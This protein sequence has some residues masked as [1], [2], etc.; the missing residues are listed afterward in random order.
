MKEIRKDVPGTIEV[1]HKRS[2]LFFNLL[3]VPLDAFALLASF[4]AAYFIRVEYSFKP[5]VY[6]V[7]GQEYL[8]A[9][10]VLAPVSILLFAL[11]GLYNF[12]SVR[13]RWREYTRVLIATSGST[14][15]LIIVDFFSTKPIFPS[16]A[17]V[18]YGYA[19]SSLSI[20][21]LRFLL[22]SFQRTLF[23]FGIGRRQVVVVGAG[24]AADEITYS[25]QRS[26]GYQLVGVIP[27][28][29]GSIASLQR[30]LSRRVIDE[31]FLADT[32]VSDAE[33]IKMIQFAHQKQIIFKY[34]PGLASLYQTRSHSAL[35]ADLPVIEVIRTPL[36]GWWR[37][38]KTVFDWLG[39]LLGVILLSPFFI[40][41]AV[42]IKVTEGGT[43]FY[44]HAR[45]G[46]NGKKI[47]VWKFRTMYMRYSSGSKYSGK[48]VEQVLEELGDP[49]LIA[50]FKRD[51]KL[52]HDPRV[53]SIGRI[54][55]RLSL[56]ELPQLFNVLA[57]ELSLI[58]PRPV[59]VDELDRYQDKAG[60]FLLI[61]PGITGLWQVSG[62]NDISYDERIKLDVYYVEKWSA[63]LDL[64][65]L[66]RTILVILLGKGY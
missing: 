43:V 50:E 23:H 5:T 62:R 1:M 44:R 30:I 41:V 45:I 52:K 58:G 61:K 16:K 37:I 36:S 64:R 7:P 48:T 22:N 2:E 3:A 66:F 59:T 14:M 11:T 39:A 56:D 24:A 34:V 32:R 9:L 12:D 19:L 10:I 27:T 51:Q 55:R 31:I 25:V 49:K 8:A 63:A 57:G 28:L 20:I 4:V 60:T 54:L 21:G 6:A 13:S 18:I 47:Q 35:F 42:I 38:Y 65:I 53:T 15:F 26:K 33:Q 46:R 40:L 17:V 29:K